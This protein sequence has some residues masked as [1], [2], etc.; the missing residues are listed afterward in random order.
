MQFKARSA[1]AHSIEPLL[2]HVQGRHLLAYEQHLPALSH[3]LS[4]NVDDGLGLAC[5]WRAFDHKAA[6]SLGILDDGYLRR[7]CVDNVQHV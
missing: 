6:S 2:D 5:A 1:Q 3:K 4:D 7:V